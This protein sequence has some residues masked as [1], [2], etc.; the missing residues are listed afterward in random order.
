MYE[1]PKGLN[2]LLFA[3]FWERFSYFAMLSGFALYLNERLHLRARDA[4]LLVR[5]LVG[6]IRIPWATAVRIVLGRSHG[7]SSGDRRAG[8][9]VCACNG[10]IC[11]L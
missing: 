4:R 8:C 7:S 10:A 9:V 6:T 5:A 2:R 1:R 11:S 3:E